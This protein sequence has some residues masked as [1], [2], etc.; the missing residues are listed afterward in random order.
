MWFTR[1]VLEHVRLK[2]GNGCSNGVGVDCISGGAVY[3]SQGQ[4][5]V[6]FCTFLDN[7]STVSHPQSSLL[8]PCARRLNLTTL[9][10]P[11]DTPGL[12]TSI[13]GV[14]YPLRG[15]SVRHLKYWIRR[16]IRMWR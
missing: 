16:S 9:S 1:L 12:L 11:A 13:T 6:R 3:V 7:Y 4:L 10:G 8:Y 14:P 5:V 15:P 2:N